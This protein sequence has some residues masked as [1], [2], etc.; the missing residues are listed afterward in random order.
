[1]SVR[2]HR[3]LFGDSLDEAAALFAQRCQNLDPPEA[4]L[5]HVLDVDNRIDAHL[6]LLFAGGNDVI[7]VLSENAAESAGGGYAGTR[8]L[9]RQGQ[10]SA[11]GALA[12]QVL[13]TPDDPDRLALGE[14]GRL[15]ALKAAA[16]HEAWAGDLEEAK[17]IL[18]A[19]GEFPLAACL[20]YAAGYQRWD[21]AGALKA[22]LAAGVPDPTTWLWALGQI[23]EAQSREVLLPFLEAT[24]APVCRAAA[25]ALCRTEDDQMA[26]WLASQAINQLWAPAVLAFLG[27]PRSAGL[28]AKHI[29]TGDAFAVIAA[30]LL[31][32]GSLVSVVLEAMSNPEQAV[33][34]A[35]ALHLITGLAPL[36]QTEV[37]VVPPEEGDEEEPPFV[38]TEDQQWKLSKTQATWTESLQRSRLPFTPGVRYRFGKPA[39]PAQS[40]I[41]LRS[42]H[43]RQELRALVIDELFVR[44]GLGVHLRADQHAGRQL[45]VLDK[46]E[47]FLP[48]MVTKP[49]PGHFTFQGRR[50]VGL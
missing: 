5:H 15:D 25:L 29:E 40:L 10:V 28:L 9:L 37:A 49:M 34:A 4:G 44:F 42:G 2:F 3:E 14:L 23:G 41:A 38:H 26:V 16:A 18:S 27:G 48:H 1:M 43:L 45:R 20:A 11:W 31:G 30:G 24:E 39:D 19:G 12:E 33:Q 32:D 6:D 13:A 17:K 36:E 7:G 50:A 21:V 47:Q 46:L 22:G 8:A 35:Q